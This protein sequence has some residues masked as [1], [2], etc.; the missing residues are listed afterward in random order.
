[1][2]SREDPSRL[3]DTHRF[4]GQPIGDDVLL[5]VL[6]AT[7]WAPSHANCQPWEFIVV[8]DAD[9]RRELASLLLDVQFRPRNVGEG[10]VAWFVEAPAV[11]VVAMDR[12]RAK[13]KIGADGVQRFG[14]IDIGAAVMSVLF[15]AAEK[16]ISASMVREFDR[17]GLALLLDLPHHIEPLLVMVMG[18]A[19]GM[20]KD[21]PHLRV[22]E[23]V[24]WDRWGE[25]P[26]A[27]K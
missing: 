23:Y 18:Y 27:G 7:S 2:I 13:A 20:G 25:F 4:N 19:E 21:R 3:G 24:H 6:G 8:H 15:H 10:E 14:L 17:D 12:L 11:I 16:G 1:M 22:D 5:D 26:L 9:R